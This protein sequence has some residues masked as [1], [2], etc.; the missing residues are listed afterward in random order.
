MVFRTLILASEFRIYVFRFFFF[1]AENERSKKGKKDK[2]DLQ[3]EIEKLKREER[4]LEEERTKLEAKLLSVKAELDLANK[5]I[6]EGSH[7][8][9]QLRLKHQKLTNEIS[10]SAIFTNSKGTILRIDLSLLLPGC[11]SS[12]PVDRN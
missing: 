1:L 6:K 7:E 2:S 12:F 10:K 9:E 11:C 5:K 8:E 4:K 3:A